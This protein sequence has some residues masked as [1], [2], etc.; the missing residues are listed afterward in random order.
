MNFDSVQMILPFVVDILEKNTQSQIIAE[1]LDRY[2]FE[3]ENHTQNSYETIRK[4]H[5]ENHIY[6]LAQRVADCGKSMSFDLYKKQKIKVLRQIFLCKNKFCLNCQKQKQLTRLFRFGPHLDKTAETYDLYHLVLTVP[7]CSS[8][9][10]DRKLKN[11]HSAFTKLINFL[12]TGSKRRPRKE[13]INYGCVACVRSTEITYNKLKRKKGEEY[14]PH[15]HVILALNKNL[16]FKKD[17]INKYSFD[18]QNNKKLSRYFS[19]FEIRLQK[20]WF[21]L[22][23]KEKYTK[24]NF[25]TVKDGYSVTLDLIDENTYYEVFKYATKIFDENSKP[26]EYNQFC[27]LNEVLLKKR[28]MQGYGKWYG[29]QNDEEIEEGFLEVQQ[30]IEAYLRKKEQ[31]LRVHNMIDEI[32]KDMTEDLEYLYL[33][34]KAIHNLEKEDIEKIKKIS[35]GKQIKNIIEKLNLNKIQRTIDNHLKNFK[36]SYLQLRGRY[37]TDQELIKFRKSFKSDLRGRLTILNEPYQDFIKEMSLNLEQIRDK[38]ELIKVNK[39]LKGNN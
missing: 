18:Y 30:V 2:I 24:Q 1:F 5:K 35:S 6:D 23:N 31:P 20:I 10:L 32:L 9:E 36:K 22:I 13:F 17:I 4:K 15:L 25:E 7:N 8:N 27:T 37:P 28:T 26:I 21:L 39:I 3:C 38:K 19:E 33:N 12:L 14:H 34:M 16:D 29:I 11:M